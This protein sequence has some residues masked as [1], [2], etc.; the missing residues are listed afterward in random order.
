[1]LDFEKFVNTKMKFTQK[2]KSIMKLL[3]TRNNVIPKCSYN[4]A[5]VYLLGSMNKHGIH[6][7]MTRQVKNRVN[8]KDFTINCAT[9][10]NLMISFLKP[11]L[12]KNIQALKA[13]FPQYNVTLDVKEMK[14]FNT[15]RH[16][17]KHTVLGMRTKFGM[18]AILNHTYGRGFDHNNSKMPIAAHQ[19]VI[20]MTLGLKTKNPLLQETIHALFVVSSKDL[21]LVHVSLGALKSS[22]N[23]ETKPILLDSID[24]I[25]N[26]KLFTWTNNLV[27]HPALIESRTNAV[28]P[29]ISQALKTFYNFKKTQRRHRNNNAK[30]KKRKRS[31]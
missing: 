1:M 10:S 7:N 8:Q 26:K 18:T 15:I 4:R 21:H 30:Q 16:N 2:E 14:N 19:F 13:Q 31:T 20:E 11:A 22:Q 5:L 25:K 27:Y 17:G 3:E 12:E 9:L 24:P 23:L 29:V 6:S 28:T